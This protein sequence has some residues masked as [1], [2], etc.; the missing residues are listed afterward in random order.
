MFIFYGCSK[1]ELFRGQEFTSDELVIWAFIGPDNGVRVSVQRLVG[2]DKTD[3][4][5]FITGA[6]VEIESQSG[7]RWHLDS[8]G[9]GIYADT[10]FIPEEN[11]NYRLVVGSE[12]YKTA[13]SD[14]VKL[15]SKLKVK[16]IDWTDDYNIYWFVSPFFP[17]STFENSKY[18]YHLR[19]EVPEDVKDYDI[20]LL[21]S[22]GD[23]FDYPI[24]KDGI[25]DTNCYFVIQPPEDIFLNNDSLYLELYS[26]NE[27]E[28]YFNIFSSGNSNYRFIWYS[29][30]SNI[31]NGIGAFISYN[32]VKSS[33]P[34]K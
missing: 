23:Y 5:N 4:S 13:I 18:M 1:D 19:F 11:V 28:I 20:F 8:V 25:I 31:N 21:D 6:S 17:L 33:I 10:N 34:I 22:S 26:Y 3:S 2:F 15:P 9:I 14:W 30:F 29:N 7:R 24:F 27:E 12:G 16:S 32:I